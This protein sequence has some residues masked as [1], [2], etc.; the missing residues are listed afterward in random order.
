MLF[1]TAHKEP[2]H[3]KNKHVLY[4]EVKLLVIRAAVFYFVV[5]KK[6]TKQKRLCKHI[7][8]KVTVSNDL[9]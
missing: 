1:Q 5:V 8:L 4:K 9:R 6:Q 3:L 2:R 7:I